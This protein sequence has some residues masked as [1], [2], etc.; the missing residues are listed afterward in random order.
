MIAFYILYV[1]AIIEYLNA[2]DVAKFSTFAYSF[3]LFSKQWHTRCIL[4][5]LCQFAEENKVSAV[6][7][8]GKC[9]LIFNFM[10]V[11]NILVLWQGFQE[12]L[13]ESKV[14]FSESKVFFCKKIKWFSIKTD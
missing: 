4:R 2:F 12:K 9:S 11:W 3:S 7:T 10:R 13:S 1:V 14:F 6:K 8:R 5:D